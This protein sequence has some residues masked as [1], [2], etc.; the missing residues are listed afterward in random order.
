MGEATQLPHDSVRLLSIRKGSIITDFEVRGQMALVEKSLSHINS[1]ITGRTESGLITS[2]CRAVISDSI[3]DCTVT[4]LQLRTVPSPHGTEN[5]ANQEQESTRQEKRSPWDNWLGELL[6]PATL[7]LVL[8][9]G[10]FVTPIIIHRWKKTQCTWQ[11]PVV[12]VPSDH[13]FDSDKNFNAD[14]NVL[15]IDEEKG[16]P[17]DEIRSCQSTITPKSFTVDDIEIQSVASDLKPQDIL[18]ADS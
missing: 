17:D 7:I 5:Q 11:D 12:P 9:L 2:L 4:V 14:K 8:M 15:C 3:A 18:A 1:Q 13:V 16:K 6:I 10:C